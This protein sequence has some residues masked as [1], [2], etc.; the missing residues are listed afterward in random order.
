MDVK[1]LNDELTALLSQHFQI[2]ATHSQ[3]Q[4]QWY[5]RS[6]QSFTS[7][8]GD[9]KPL[10]LVPHTSKEEWIPHLRQFA[11]SLGK[12]LEIARRESRAFD[13]IP[14]SKLFSDN[15]LDEAHTRPLCLAITDSKPLSPDMM[16]MS[17]WTTKIQHPDDKARR[18]KGI[19]ALIACGQVDSLIR[20]ALLPGVHPEQASHIKPY[21]WES[22]NSGWHTAVDKIIVIMLFLGITGTFAED[23]VEKDGY[24]YW[25]PVAFFTYKSPLT[26]YIDAFGGKIPSSEHE[27]RQQMTH[28]IEALVATQSWALSTGYTINWGERIMDNF[29]YMLGFEAWNRSREGEGYLGCDLNKTKTAKSLQGVGYDEEDISTKSDEG[30]TKKPID[31]LKLRDPKREAVPEPIEEERREMDALAVLESIEADYG[32]KRSTKYISKNK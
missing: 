20:L 6:Y 29:L 21:Q 31:P 1:F 19:K 3:R 26:A 15:V 14:E 23:L 5:K 9:R 32:R 13:N 28:C 27:R 17:W 2:V 25:A 10:I 16:Q 24:K 22:L 4:D 12:K 8:H 18:L 7:Q 30:S 11:S